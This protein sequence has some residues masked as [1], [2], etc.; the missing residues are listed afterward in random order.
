M[1]T[2]LNF[3]LDADPDPAFDFD[4]N[5]DPAFYSDV[6]P[7]PD[8]QHFCS[9]VAEKMEEVGE[10]NAQIRGAEKKCWLARWVG[11]GGLV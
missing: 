3:D 11:G 1:S 6:D 9:F 4:E 10:R 8:P 2:A 5:L 7:D